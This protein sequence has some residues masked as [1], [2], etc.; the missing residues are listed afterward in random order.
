MEYTCPKIRKI[1]TY[2]AEGRCANGSIANIPRCNA[3][4]G[5]ATAQNCA[6]GGVASN[7]P[8][9]CATGKLP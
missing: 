6:N 1:K 4:T 8:V 5:G 7:N 2:P 3:G 9:G